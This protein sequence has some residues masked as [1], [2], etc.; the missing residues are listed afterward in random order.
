MMRKIK[1][2]ILTSLL[3][4]CKSIFAETE[5]VV[6][7]TF[8]AIDIPTD[9][10][11][12]LIVGYDKII[13]KNIQNLSN[14]MFFANS[15]GYPVGTPHI[16]PFPH[17]TS[18]LALGAGLTNMSYFDED[19]KNSE[20][21]PSGGIS[22]GLLWGSG[23]SGKMDYILK[24]FWYDLL[25][26]DPT[27]NPF[28]S[29]YPLDMKE[30]TL[31]LFGGKIRYMLV[32][33]K[34]LIPFLFNLR[35]INI[36]LGAD[37]MRGT[38]RAAGEYDKTFDLGTVSV[39][40]DGAGAA[41]AQDVDVY[42]EISEYNVELQ[43]LQLSLTAQAFMYFNIIKILNFYTGP[44][45][46]IGYGFFSLEAE[47]DGIV[48]TDDTTFRG[49]AG[50]AAG[51]TL[52]N[53]NLTSESRYSPYPWIPAYTFGLELNLPFLKITA[54]TSVNLYNKEDITASVGTRVEF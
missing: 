17:F 52:A 13:D 28:L 22:G 5:L 7:S 39:D 36:N 18:G 15:T 54:D 53:A 23:L 38:I 48:N 9:S 1:I 30:F 24:V 50:M 44:S 46:T 26:Y 10:L 2:I 3:I 11:D 20:D 45:A 8:G 31:F 14:G 12:E 4:F 40:P 21:L 16:K 29:D 34:K 32:G 49:A 33:E 37:L 19:E 6:S 27:D 25:I 47:I 41:P 43:W 51:D 42:L 35:G